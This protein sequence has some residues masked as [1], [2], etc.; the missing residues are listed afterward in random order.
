MILQIRRVKAWIM[1]LVFLII[2]VAVLAL[3][4]NILL[5]LIPIVIVII[6][7]SYLFRMLNKVKKEKPKDYIDIK[8]KEKK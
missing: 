1:I 5:F 4:F 8:F 3:A 7:A 2:T 6:I